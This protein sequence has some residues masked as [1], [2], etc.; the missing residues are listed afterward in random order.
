MRLGNGEHPETLWAALPRDL[1]ARFRPTV[2]RLTHDM[3][4]EIQRTVPA[5]AGP[6]EGSF[7]AI[8]TAA[9][10]QAVL[11]VLD[12]AG[13]GSVAE[14]GWSDVFRRLG[15]VEFRAGRTL[16]ALQTAYRVG[17][18]VAW[19][20]VAAWGEANRVPVGVFSLVAEAIFAYVE[21]ISSLSVEG[22]T[23]AQTE[24]V[25]VM[26]R[27]RRKLV[28]L[29]MAEPAASPGAIAKQAALARWQ[30]PETVAI[31]AL[32][33]P[34]D[35]LD[36][37]QPSHHE[38]ILADLGS[39]MPCLIMADPRRHIRRLV[40]ELR[41]RVACVGP[42]VALSRA[43]TSLRLARRTVDLVRRGVIRGG[44]VTWCR[45]HL[46]T[47]WLFADEFLVAE[48]VKRHLAPL[49][50]MTVKQ[51][52]RVIETVLAW[53]YTRG[54]APEIAD[55]LDIHPQTVRYRMRQVEKLFGALLNDPQGRLE[56]EIA[57]R[58][59]LLSSG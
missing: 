40:A 7:G 46:A 21:E 18:R 3:I 8:M 32:D 24:S 14:D 1:A 5:Y 27:H 57:L 6:L 51:R 15:E 25:Q 30:V 26:A 16:D 20:H 10:E 35:G 19:R 58:A 45:D 56:L 42:T 9:V 37:P 39:D 55:R 59:Q 54:S 22:Y 47:L 29:I 11:R 48:L 17:G 50:G 43:V 28:E 33:Q 13:T 44:T 53:L 49:V 36:V 34:E 41:G 2:G 38:E 4:E 31:I 12:M 23:S 52:D